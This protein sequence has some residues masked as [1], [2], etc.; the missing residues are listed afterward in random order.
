M[1]SSNSEPRPKLTSEQRSLLSVALQDILLSQQ[2]SSSPQHQSLLQYIVKHSAA[3]EENLLRERVIG[4]EVFHRPADY[5]PGQDPVVRIRISDLR[6][7]LA[8]YYQSLPQTPDVSISIPVG[9]YRAAFTFHTSEEKDPVEAASVTEAPVQVQTTPDHHPDTEPRQTRNI[10]RPLALALLLIVVGFVGFLGWKWAS[11]RPDK[12]VRKFWAPLISTNSPVILAIGSN[13]VYRMSEE[14]SDRY[15]KEHHLESE[16]MEVFPDLSP[17]QTLASTGI[18]ATP[19]SFVALGDVA[20]VSDL[21]RILTQL[22]KPQQNRFT[23]DISFAE[24]RSNP[25]VAIGGFNNRMTREFTQNMRFFFAHR[26]R[27]EDRQNA[28]QAWDLHASLDSHNTEDFAIVTRTL[29]SSGNAAF[30][31]LAGLGQYGTLAATE[32][33]CDPSSINSLD[34]VAPDWQ[35]KN[36]QLVLRIKVVDYKAVSTNI[37]ATY[38]W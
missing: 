26:T 16:G 20:A 36:L 32:F 25:T 18:H 33:V 9:S 27:I 21:S 12:A 17:T 35:K 19:D 6:K 15:V 13:A 5:D 22:N 29:P 10:W 7:R 2:F 34:K 4:A 11:A 1:P 31:S 14:V 37:I 23:N 38:T 30:L 28:K 3:G 24:V 8:I